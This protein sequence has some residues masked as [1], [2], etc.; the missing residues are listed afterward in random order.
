MEQL[1]SRAV[2]SNLQGEKRPAGDPARLVK[3]AYDA[4]DSCLELQ[5]IIDAFNDQEDSPKWAFALARMAAR[6]TDLADAAHGEAVRVCGVSGG[7]E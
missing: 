2:T 4:Y 7:G 5:S 3:L 1:N 6:A